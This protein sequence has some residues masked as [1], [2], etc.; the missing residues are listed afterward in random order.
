MNGLR[1]ECGWG[2]LLKINL[3]PK[4]LTENSHDKDNKNK[5]DV[6]LAHVACQV[7]STFNVR[8]P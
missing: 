4:H 6:N 3:N 1:L 2:F 5:P 7:K 8:I